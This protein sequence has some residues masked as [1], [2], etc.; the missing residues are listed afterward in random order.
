MI[1]D[2]D[3]PTYDYQIGSLSNLS[4]ACLIFRAL[5]S[6]SIQRLQAQ[7][8]PFDRNIVQVAQCRCTVPDSRSHDIEFGQ[9]AVIFILTTFS[10]IS[11]C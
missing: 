5:G 6:Y 11:C 2:N 8:P 4:N 1:T 3:S 10:L 9:F 7:F